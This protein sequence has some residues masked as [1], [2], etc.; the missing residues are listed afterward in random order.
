MS[1]RV[2]AGLIAALLA[3]GATAAF[4]FLPDGV[5]SVGVIDARDRLVPMA[6]VQGNAFWA[7]PPGDRVKAV[8]A[9]DADGEVIWRSAPVPLPDE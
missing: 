3:L 4:L 8:V 2:G 9:L 5:H 6:R 1:R 7:N